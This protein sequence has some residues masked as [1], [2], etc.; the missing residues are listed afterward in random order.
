MKKNTQAQG[1]YIYGIVR[2]GAPLH[3]D[4]CGVDKRWPRIEEIRSDDICA[5]VSRVPREPIAATREHL[6]AHER[7]NRAVLADRTVIPMA[8][9]T[10]CRSRE[11][12]A[13]VLRS[14]YDAF[15]EALEQ[16]NGK[17]EF[18][19]QGYRHGDTAAGTDRAVPEILRQ[20]GDVSLA[21]RLNAPFGPGMVMNAAFLVQRSG[22]AGFDHGVREISQRYPDLMFKRSGPWPPYN[23]VRIRLQLER[24]S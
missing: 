1:F 16:M 22:E 9:G 17:L 2:A 20:L 12:V 11:D 19:L 23:F 13:Q 3:A 6:L 14:G 10:Q 8:F 4:C 15:S 18:G 7:V 21:S 5:V 24:P